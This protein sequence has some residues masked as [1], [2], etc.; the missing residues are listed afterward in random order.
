M[1]EISNQS[2]SEIMGGGD[3]DYA[4]TVLLIVRF[5]TRLSIASFLASVSKTSTLKS[6]NISPSGIDRIRRL[7]NKFVLKPLSK[8]QLKPKGLKETATI[9]G[10]LEYAE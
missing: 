8:P 6:L 7:L 5:E 9:A 3:E 4:K 10:L 1:P 2:L